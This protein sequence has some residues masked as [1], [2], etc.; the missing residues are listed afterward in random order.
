MKK[1]A[2]ATVLSF[3]LVG[4]G[5]AG[6]EAVRAQSLEDPAGYGAPEEEEIVLTLK[7]TPKP[8][9]VPEP[10]TLLLMGLGGVAL[11]RNRRLLKRS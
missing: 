3:L 7:P 10:A 1:L 11:F 6:T 2:V 8:R 4:A 9:P 5:P